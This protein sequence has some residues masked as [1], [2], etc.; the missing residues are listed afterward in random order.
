MKR[1]NIPLLLLFSSSLSFAMEKRAKTYH[2]EKIE[3]KSAKNQ[4][5]IEREAIEDVKVKEDFEE[6]QVNE[7]SEQINWEKLPE[8][9]KIY[10]LSFVLKTDDALSFLDSNNYKAFTALFKQWMILRLIN[11]EMSN[12]SIDKTIFDIN[13]IIK[14]LEGEKHQ[15][16]FSGL[17]N[18]FAKFGLVRCL[19]L[20]LKN[21]FILKDQNTGLIGTSSQNWCHEFSKELILNG[22]FEGVTNTKLAHAIYLHEY[23]KIQNLIENGMDQAKFSNGSNE[24]MMAAETGNNE[25]LKLVLG[26]ESE[27][28]IL[29]DSSNDTKTV[30]VNKVDVNAKNNSGMTA[31]MFGAM[32]NDKSIV[33]LL[34]QSGAKVNQKSNNKSSALFEAVWCGHKGIVKVLLKNRAGINRGGPEKKTVLME[35]A[36]L[37]HKEIVNLLLRKGA[38]IHGRDR[39]GSPAL[40]YAASGG[41]KGT[42]ETLLKRANEIGNNLDNIDIKDK[43]GNTALLFAAFNGHKEVVE[44]LLKSGADPMIK[45]DDGMTALDFATEKGYQDIVELLQDYIDKL[46]GN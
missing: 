18:N 4:N 6:I 42:L 39:K 40:L 41:E 24:I 44:F 45:L 10:I 23:D 20:L 34:I 9:T 32:S 14:Y 12:L 25:I 13:K 27:N 26:L 43:S 7:L 2:K 30:V 22:I 11:E 17:L 19:R 36:Y 21:G 15:A 3:I 31:L 16:Y 29:V 5:E 33:K 1:I 8:E 35:A 37:G 28:N 46:N 38:K